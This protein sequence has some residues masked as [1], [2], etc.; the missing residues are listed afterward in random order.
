MD[1]ATPREASW[2]RLKRMARYLQQTEHYG[3]WLPA[4]GEPKQIIIETD[5]D[6]AGCKRT[7]RSRGAEA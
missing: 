1:M 3:A 4:A 5:A 2:A 7:R 6:W